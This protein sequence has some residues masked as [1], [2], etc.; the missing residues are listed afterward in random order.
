LF[1]DVKKVLIIVAVA[2][3]ILTAVIVGF[4]YAGGIILTDD[5]DELYQGVLA[6]QYI[7]ASAIGG[8]GEPI[9]EGTL[10]ILHDTDNVSVLPTDPKDDESG[11][12]GRPVAN[13]V[14]VMLFLPSGEL[15]ASGV[16][17]EGNNT[18]SLVKSFDLMNVDNA[19][20]LPHMN[21]ERDMLSYKEVDA[22]LDRGGYFRVASNGYY[23]SYPIRLKSIAEAE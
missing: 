5:R 11:E 1:F 7:T 14:R 19:S 13:S 8:T 10:E 18:F 9:D 2:I 21:R 20:G 22:V 3:G 4:L 23:I 6:E 15:V 17:P 12:T 16:V